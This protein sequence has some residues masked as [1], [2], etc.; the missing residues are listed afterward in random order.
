MILCTVGF[1]TKIYKTPNISSTD[2]VIHS[3]QD[4]I[5]AIQNTA[6]ESMLVT[7]GNSHTEELRD[8]DKIFDNVTPQGRHPRVVTQ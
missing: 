2:A 1:P 3:T 8:L 7:L 6:P 5:H 4:L